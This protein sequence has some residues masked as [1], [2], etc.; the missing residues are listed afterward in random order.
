MTILLAVANRHGSTYEIATALAHE[1]QE[2]GH[3][4]IVRNAADV[5]ATEPYDAVIIGSAVYMGAWL[6]EARHFVERHQARLQTVPVW[7]FSSGPLGRDD[8]QPH[9]APA[10]LAELMQTTRARE[11]HLFAGKLDKAALGRGERLVVSVVKAP[12]GDFRDWEAIRGWAR[13][14]AAAVPAPVVS[15]V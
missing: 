12:E 3:T 15:A 6:P 5:A 9:G 7:L 1:L 14:I 13:A 10:H 8:V 4:A 11:H 2:A